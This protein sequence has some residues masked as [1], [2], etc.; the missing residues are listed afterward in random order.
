MSKHVTPQVKP[1]A[2]FRRSGSTPAASEGD[3]EPSEPA[4]SADMERR[5]SLGALLVQAGYASEQDIKTTITEGLETGERLGEIVVRKGWATDEEIAQ[6]LAEQWQLRYLPREELSVDPAAARR[7]PLEMARELRALPVALEGDTVVVALAE[8]GHD[9]FARLSE[10]VGDTSFVVV[11]ASALESL[12]ASPLLAS[13]THAESPAVAEDEIDEPV[14]QLETPFELETEAFVPEVE[15]EPEIRAVVP[16]EEVEP[17]AAG[18]ESPP[19][20]VAFKRPAAGTLAEIAVT[21]IEN[22]MG[23]LDRARSEIAALGASL[24]LARDQLGEQEDELEAAA[25]AQEQDAETIRRLENELA[26]QSEL[27]E[28]L[29]QQVATLTHTLNADTATAV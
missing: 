18:L 13:G 2:R 3:T 5:P 22:A 23:E 11:S 20:A 24:E 17:D 29:K 26:R 12:F 27:F 1:D 16:E 15:L 10:R 14:N 6:L 7:M 9:L 28:T 19:E 25:E 4:E 21:T 8:P